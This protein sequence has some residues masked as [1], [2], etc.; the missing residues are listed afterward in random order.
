LRERKS[1]F[2]EI[3][4]ST[5]TQTV[6]PN[7]YVLAHADGCAFTPQCSYCYLKSSFWYLSGAQV[8]TNINEMLHEVR[9]WIARDRLE[10]YML[11]AGNLSDSLTFEK[12]R[13]LMKKLVET[14]REAAR[15]R[16]HTLLIVTKGGMRECEAF[17]ET[18][19]CENVVISFSVNHPEAARRHESGA[20]PVADRLKA[21]GAL[22]KM[23]WRVRI[24]IDPMILG[25]DYRPIAESVRRLRPERV[26]LGSLRSEPNL[27]RFVGNGLFKDIEHPTDG[28]GLG[29]YALEKRI[30][31]YR[32]AADRLLDICP[33]A[34]CEEIPAVWD[35]LGLD[36]QAKP[37]NCC[38]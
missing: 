8:F 29:R 2:V 21:A 26:T 14:F 31:L 1:R 25:Y 32:Q 33:V 27:F 15:G 37:C 4:R 34:L 5:P 36:K 23:G 20:A 30:A 22:K 3:F 7:F 35:A 19:P 11:N 17:L 6:C 28:K 24:R 18:E 16:R 10:S 9:Q 38:A 13:P 12:R